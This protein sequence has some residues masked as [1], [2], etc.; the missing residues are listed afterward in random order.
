M[1]FVDDLLKQRRDMD[2]RTTTVPEWRTKDGKARA[3]YAK[4]LTMREL[5]L[6]D[7]YGQKKNSV[8]A[9][10]VKLAQLSFH[11]AD[12]RQLI[13]LNELDQFEAA[14]DPNVLSRVLGE[15]GLFEQDEL[16]AFEEAEKNSDTTL[17][18]D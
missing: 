13:D 3:V 10:L 8:T 6:V 14:C 4:P 1:S 9:R 18:D 7:L 2:W 17:E 12:G 11:D 16:A 5:R 15:L